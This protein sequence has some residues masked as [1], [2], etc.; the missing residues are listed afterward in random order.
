LGYEFVVPQGAF[1]IFPKSP[2][3]DEVKFV[4][5]ALKHRILLVPGRGFGCEEHFRFSYSVEKYTLE[6]SKTQ[7]LKLQEDVNSYSA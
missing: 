7:F 2:L 4:E 5:L 6:R 3:A 1:F